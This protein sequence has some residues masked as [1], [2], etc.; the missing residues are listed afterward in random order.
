[1]VKFTRLS[2]TDKLASAGTKTVTPSNRT[3]S[4]KRPS[5]GGS[6]P[7]SAKREGELEKEI[8]KKINKIEKYAKMEEIEEGKR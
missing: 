5:D 2:K 7:T 1:M 6:Q 4:Q 8:Q 3:G